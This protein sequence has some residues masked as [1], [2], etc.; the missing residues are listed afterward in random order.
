MKEFEEYFSEIQA[1]MISICLE[2]VNNRAEKIYLYASCEGNIAF[3]SFFY[4]INNIYVK[5]H[6]LNDAIDESE[7]RYDVSTERQFAVLNIINDDVKKIKNLCIEYERDVPT[8]LKL[9]YDVKKNSLKA[10]YKYDLVYSN[11][12][13]KTANHVAMEWFEQIKL[14]SND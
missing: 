7:E 5:K 14:E 1:D 13:V 9:I 11:D 3:S 8:E 2:Y 4:K 6:N 10:E 12:S